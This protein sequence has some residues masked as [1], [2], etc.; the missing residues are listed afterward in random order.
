MKLWFEKFHLMFW[1]RMHYAHAYI[2]WHQGERVL[3]ARH[4][5]KMFELERKLDL[6]EFQKCAQ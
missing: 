3:S 6:L 1:I 2:Y 5:N 4:E